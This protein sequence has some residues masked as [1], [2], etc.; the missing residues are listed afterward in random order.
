M[1]QGAAQLEQQLLDTGSCCGMQYGL[2]KTHFTSLP[3]E[4]RVVWLV[5]EDLTAKAICELMLLQP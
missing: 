3:S 1:G 2:E 5:A 4:S